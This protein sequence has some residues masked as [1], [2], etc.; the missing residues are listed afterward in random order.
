MAAPIWQAAGLDPTGVGIYLVNDKELNSFVAGGQAIFLNSGLILR[1]KYP[2][3]LIGVIAH[4]T[5]HIAGGHVLRSLEAAKNASIE[6]IIALVAAVG[7]S[8]AGGSGAPI[9]A[10][11]GMGQRAYMSFS[12]AQEATADHAAL[13]YLDRTGQSA[14]GLLKFFEILQANEPL[15]GEPTDPWARTHPLTSERIDYIRHHVETSRYSDAPDPPQSVELLKR[16]QMKLHAFLDD[17]SAT[18]RAYPD[19]DQSPDARYARAIAYYRIPRLDKA[20]PAIDAL[21]HDF[22]T[23]PYYQE[24]KGQMLFENGRI[25]DAIAPYEQAVKLAPD[26]ALMRISLAQVYIES[27]D[28]ALTKRAI[29]YLNDA[30]QAEGRE[31]MLWRLLA[32]AYGRDNQLG[33]AALSLAEEALADTKKKDAQQ[34]AQRAKQL[35]PKNT[36]AYARAEEIQREAKD[37]DSD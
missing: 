5:G 10:A 34:Q 18:L 8:V 21:I 16:V 17:P 33:M 20:V 4:E 35:L 29:A 28:P 22:P 12:V 32:T 7:A 23:N 9:I 3:M 27:N 15:T 19:S 11:A 2:N 13:N 25:R 24:L 30:A 26:A 31:G 14:R 1:A 37:L 36:A 6:T